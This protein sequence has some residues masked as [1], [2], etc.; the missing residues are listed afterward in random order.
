MWNVAEQSCVVWSSSLTKQNITELERIQKVAVRIILGEYYPYRIGLKMLNFGTIKHRRHELT[1]LSAK[2]ALSI[3][4]QE[5]CL[6]LHKT[7]TQWN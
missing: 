1:K 2:N 6:K 4:K 5:Q 7:N 3:R